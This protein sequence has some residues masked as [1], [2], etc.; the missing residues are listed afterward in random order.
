M[1]LP[2]IN[3]LGDHLACNTTPIGKDLHR[4][5]FRRIFFQLKNHI[6]VDSFR[7]NNCCVGIKI[8]H[9]MDDNGIC[10]FFKIDTKGTIGVG[11]DTLKFSALQIGSSNRCIRR[12]FT[13]G[14]S[15]NTFQACLSQRA[16]T[17]TGKKKSKQCSQNHGLPNVHRLKVLVPIWRITNLCL[18]IDNKNANP[19]KTIFMFVL[20]LIARKTY[21]RLKAI[22]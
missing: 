20:T 8:P 12:S 9:E 7:Y 17:V 4:S 15:N 1:R 3:C 16:K 19:K 18:Q 13:I 11:I 14:N 10:A 21:E 6:L 2:R 22:T 5:Q